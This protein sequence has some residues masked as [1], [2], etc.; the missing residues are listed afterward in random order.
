MRTQGLP[1]VAVVCAALAAAA[2]ANTPTAPTVWTPSHVREQILATNLNHPTAGNR[3]R[4]TRW[5]V[6]IA[7]N[8]NGIAR[9]E[10]AVARL[11]SW[12]GG[13]IR[14]TRISGTPANGLTFVEGGARDVER[15]CVDVVNHGVEPRGFVP[16]W[17]AGS[18]LTGVYTLHLG[19]ARCDDITR[20]RY[21]TAY[22]EHILG[23]ALGIF[24]HFSGF[25]GAEG[26]VDAHA[27]AVLLNLYANPVG[28]TADQLVMWPGSGQ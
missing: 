26:L 2:C 14:F 28:A 16:T 27:F 12:S 22:A 6:P 4:L 15:G 11:E 3:G 8:T 1:A 25:T 7:V 9:A 21:A 18:A 23:H 17:D 20:G 5:R 24:D 10:E 19:S 13:V